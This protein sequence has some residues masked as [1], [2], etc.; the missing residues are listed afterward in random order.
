MHLRGQTFPAHS[1][2]LLLVRDRWLKYYN[3]PELTNPRLCINRA[4]ENCKKLEGRVNPRV[5]AAW[6]RMIFHG[7]PTKHRTEQ[8]FVPCFTCGCENGDT[9]RHISSCKFTRDIFKHYQVVPQDETY[10]CLYFYGCHS[11]YKGDIDRL[12][13]ASLIIHGI[14]IALN[15]LRHGL[16][17]GRRLLALIGCVDASSEGAAARCS[18]MWRARY[19]RLSMAQ[20]GHLVPFL[21][22]HESA[23]IFLYPKGFRKSTPHNMGPE[24]VLLIG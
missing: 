19:L 6:I 22:M 13:I 1:D 10:N 9:F 20:P 17:P 11:N 2:P 12:T 5:Q 24:H 18:R 21:L 7:W 15:K 4:I 8:K 16:L 3:M 14:Y 23:L